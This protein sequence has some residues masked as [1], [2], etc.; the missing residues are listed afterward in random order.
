[1]EGRKIS[2]PYPFAVS[3]VLIVLDLPLA[4]FFVVRDPV[5]LFPSSSESFFGALSLLD[6]GLLKKK[7]NQELFFPEYSSAYYDSENWLPMH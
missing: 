2:K 3:W 7:T 5:L 1:M 4:F 6:L